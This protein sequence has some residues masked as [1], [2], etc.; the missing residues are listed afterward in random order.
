M[1][2]PADRALTEPTH[3]SSRPTQSRCWSGRQNVA[4]ANETETP[5]QENAF[6]WLP[7][8]SHRTLALSSLKCSLRTTW[9]VL[10]PGI[11]DSGLLGP[12][13]SKS[14]LNLLFL[15]GQL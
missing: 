9:D 13:P 14:W 3:P 6:L 12:Q 8:E 4:E 2:P 1:F 15:E 11:Q 10:G 7:P 5:L